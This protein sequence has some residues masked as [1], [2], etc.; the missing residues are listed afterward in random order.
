[1]ALAGVAALGASGCFNAP[2]PLAPGVHGSVG[3]P[4]D[5]VLTG[6]VELPV[7]GPGF[8]RYR[9]HT[10]HDW[11]TPVLVHAVEHAA[12]TVAKEM[13]GGPPLLIG[14]MSGEYGGKIPGHASHRVGRDADLLWY[15]TTPGGAPRVSPGFVHMGADGLA[16]VGPNDYVRLDIAR[17]W[18]LVK[19]LLTDKNIGVEW[20]FC[21]HLVEPLLIDYARSL[22]ED[23][24]LV[25]HAETVL[26]QPGDSASHDDHL[27]LRIVCTKEQAVAGCEGGGPRWPWLSPLPRLGPL[28]PATLAVIARDEPLSPPRTATDLP[29][30][31]V[32][33]QRAKR[34]TGAEGRS[35][36]LRRRPH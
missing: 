26:L 12:A 31:R 3:L 29:P 14:D 7:K 10:P 21:S 27:H 35:A 1:M 5:G 11:G 17:E 30:P 36:R 33:D 8:A 28:D 13:P 22:G 16:Y 25:W 32:V 9:P 23:P 24:A 4:Y 6:G 15:V 20:L 19:A 34:V 18:R 2:T